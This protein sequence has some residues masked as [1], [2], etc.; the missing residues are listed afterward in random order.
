MRNAICSGVISFP[1]FSSFGRNS[2]LVSISENN[3]HPRQFDAIIVPLRALTKSLTRH[4]RRGARQV[5]A[6]LHSSLSRS[7]PSVHFE[8]KNQ[9]GILVQTKKIPVLYQFV[10]PN[11]VYVSVFLRQRL[12]KQWSN[13]Q[14]Q[15][16]RTEVKVHFD[17]A[18][19]LCM[20]SLL[21]SCLLRILQLSS[22]LYVAIFFLLIHLPWPYKVRSQLI[23][24]LH[25]L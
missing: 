17:K 12:R 4:N 9:I 18:L 10:P 22:L 2:S 21:H 3:P 11:K 24:R 19:A 13:K 16:N 1:A 5:P 6:L 7:V 14:R 23:K 8:V 25:Q 15:G 20:H